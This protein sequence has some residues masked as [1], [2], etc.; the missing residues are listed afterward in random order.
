M[1]TENKLRMNRASIKKEFDSIT[2][3]RE[4]ITTSH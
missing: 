4:Q 2:K 3:N 1:N